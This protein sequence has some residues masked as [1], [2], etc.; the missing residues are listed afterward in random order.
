MNKLLN[1]LDYLRTYIDDL[2]IIIYKYF[3]HHIYKLDKVLNNLKQKF[4]KLNTKKFFFAKNELEYLG[5]RITRQG[6]MRLPY[7][8]EAIKNIPV[9]TTKN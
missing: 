6:I 2:L 9:P 3:E 7:K 1:G 5:F 8:V 4:L